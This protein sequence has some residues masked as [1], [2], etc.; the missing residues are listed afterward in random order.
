MDPRR[1]KQ[2]KKK[3]TKLQSQSEFGFRTQSGDC[4]PAVSQLRALFKEYSFQAVWR[5]L[6]TLDIWLPNI[7]GQIKLQLLFGVLI[8]VTPEEF[9]QAK[10][11][12]TYDDFSH[13]LTTVLK[14]VPS[15]PHIEDYIPEQD[16][17]EVLFPTT[18]GRLR[19]L[20]GCE[21]ANIYDYLI[22][23]ETIYYGFDGEYKSA[24]GRSPKSE[25]EECLQI[26]DRL[27]GTIVDQSRPRESL[28][29]GHLEI[30]TRKFWLSVIGY[31]D[32]YPCGFKYSTSLAQ[33]YAIRSGSLSEAALSSNEFVS[34]AF[35]GH[36]ITD[37][38][39][40]FD[41]TYYL[42]LPRRLTT[43]LLDHW[44][45]LY[46]KY[47]IK[48]RD[49]GMR[50]S[51][52]LTQR[53]ISFLR[54]RIHK[55]DIHLLV[56]ALEKDGTHHETIFVAA[57]R[58]RDRM[59][60]VYVA[61]PAIDSSNTSKE[62]LRIAPKIQEATKLISGP[63]ISFN[64]NFER[65]RI[66]YRPGD[67]RQS[68]EVVPLVLIPQV[69][70]QLHLSVPVE[71][72]NNLMFME[73]FLGLVDELKDT[74]E[75]S[76]FYDFKVNLEKRQQNT[77]LIS[78]LDLFAVYR[79][80]HGLIEG[81]ARR[82]D[83]ISL[84]PHGGSNM[85]FETL[86]MFWSEFP[87]AKYF[88]H[89]RSWRIA[90]ASA[91]KMR[92]VARGYLGSALFVKIGETNLFVTAPY[93]EMD[94]RTGMV[95]DLFAEVIQDMAHR[96]RNDLRT[97]CFFTQFKEAQVLIFPDSLVKGNDHFKHLRHLNP[98]DDLWVLDRGFPEPSVPGV[99]IVYN[100][101]LVKTA[102]TNTEDSKLE[103]ALFEAVLKQFD[104]VCP[105]T[106][107]NSIL[108]K[109]DA[110]SSQD[111][112]FKVFEHHQEAAIPE[113]L[114][115]I[116]ILPTDYKRARKRIAELALKEGVEPGSYSRKE[117]VVLINKLRIAVLKELGESILRLDRNQAISFLIRQIEAYC[118]SEQRAKMRAEGAKAH[119]VDYDIGASR[120]R[121]NSE[122]ISAHKNL[123]FL[124]EKFVQ[125]S[126]P[127][128]ELLVE[129][130]YRFIF[131]V[132]DWLHSLYT[133]SD[134]IHYEI[135]TLGI[136]LDNEYII[137]I[138]YP[139]G[140]SEKQDKFGKEEHDFRHGLVGNS[141]DT[142]R[143]MGISC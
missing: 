140:F 95:A 84:D 86:S 48:F 53:L 58:A 34:K 85:R 62:L 129:Q 12:E 7:S 114:K 80:T 63:P 92:L 10:R 44:K 25:L 4:D 33:N 128:E 51:M 130:E 89:P 59:F 69:E 13:F 23:F 18:S 6:F 98:A 81:G 2:K 26:Q 56:N 41:S 116:E 139:E 123:R 5:S 28:N 32:K 54:E 40:E 106:A 35:T 3:R 16:W 8:S 131:G 37:G 1:K 76:D 52:K 122:F 88:Q 67:T 93:S 109:L 132:T 50:Y 75:L 30:P 97:H 115:P 104:S 117:A 45:T 71:L 99:R 24:C 21:L 29:S 39:I 134:L 36:F 17:G 64:L 82:F 120:Q 66:E 136:S 78:I 137:A 138:N 135:E 68:M 112:R 11:I 47:G 101:S 83:F 61:D 42:M 102:F 100:D 87:K 121:S 15:F 57:I 126:P 55:D 9:T 105:D 111:P 119:A 60:L 43:V 142:F 70:T 19:I 107:L 72:G 110:L 141:E 125:V 108:V 79:G 22:H 91:D 118:H 49:H 38:F 46:A 143:T 20:Y 90:E 65:S 127:G 124:I 94:Y 31:L 74:D 77:P 73:Q 113:L 14:L 133:A 96:I 27:I 103:V